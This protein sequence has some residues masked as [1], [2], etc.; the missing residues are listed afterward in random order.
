MAGAEGVAQGSARRGTKV[1][2][3]AGRRYG[4]AYPNLFN[5]MMNGQGLDY[6]VKIGGKVELTRSARWP[7]QGRERRVFDVRVCNL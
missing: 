2:E 1:H 6:S 3:D 7:S 4:S 5:G